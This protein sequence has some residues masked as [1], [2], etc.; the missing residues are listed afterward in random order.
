MLEPWRENCKLIWKLQTHMK[1]ANSYE[2]CKHPRRNYR[3]KCENC[4]LIWKFQ[5]DMK[6]AN[7]YENCKAILTFSCMVP[8]WTFA[9]FIWDTAGMKACSGTECFGSITV[10]MTNTQRNNLLQNLPWFIF[11]YQLLCMITQSES[12]FKQWFLCSHFKILLRKIW[13]ASN[14]QFYLALIHLWL[15]RRTVVDVDLMSSTS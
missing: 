14:N 9:V 13:T 6:I 5:T 4:K 11:K 15:P 7:W 12:Y 3:P 1:I 8:T 10:W 2:N